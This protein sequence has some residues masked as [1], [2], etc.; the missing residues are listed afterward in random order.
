MPMPDVS[1][2]EMQL[3][4]EAVWPGIGRELS[5]VE[6]RAAAR[7]L[8]RQIAE[9]QSENRKLRRERDLAISRAYAAETRAQGSAR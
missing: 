7:A 1:S 9:L 6:M 5:P 2:L 8:H 4:A 3:I